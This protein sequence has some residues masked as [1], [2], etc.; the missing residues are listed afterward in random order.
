MT[1]IEHLADL[2]HVTPEELYEAFAELHNEIEQNRKYEQRR[3]YPGGTW[4]QVDVT[5]KAGIPAGTLC[6]GTH[7][8]YGRVAGFKVANRHALNP[9]RDRA[10]D[11][12]EK[13]NDL[14]NIFTPDQE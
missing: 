6:L 11:G 7:H 4:S 2:L 8:K 9:V 10:L 1:K 5:K 12:I 13:W 14:Y 3:V